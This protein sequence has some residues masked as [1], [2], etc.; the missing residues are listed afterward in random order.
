M[1]LIGGL[2][3]TAVVALAVAAPAGAETRTLIGSVSGHPGSKLIV[4]IQRVGGSPFRVTSFEF[5][6]L[7]FT[8][9]GDTPDGKISGK[10]GRMKIDKTSNPF[11]PVKQT[12]VYFSGRS[13]TT[14]DKRAAVFITGIT[15]SKAKTTRGN[16]GMSFGD[17]CS[18]DSGA[19]F[20]K[21]S[22]RR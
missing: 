2:F 19:G 9:F 11:D 8:C 13:Q 10:V 17:G 14:L 16:F 18:T 1:K 15:D 5:R 6:R 22:A 20:S 4:K 7:A 21:F 3:A 12:H